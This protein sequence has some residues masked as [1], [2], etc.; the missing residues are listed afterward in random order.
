[1]KRF[2][3]LRLLFLLPGI[4]ALLVTLYA[5]GNPDWTEQV[6]SRMVYPVLSAAVGF[7]PSLVR[8]SVAEWWVAL[9]LLFCFWYVVHCIRRIV[10]GRGVLSRKAPE[11]SGN[12]GRG[13]ILYRSVVGALAIASMLYFAFTTLCG[14]NYYRHTFT[15]YTGYGVEQSSVEEL[16]QL[17]VSL[18]GGLNQTRERL[19]QDVDLVASDREDFDQCAQDSVSAIRALAEQYPVLERPLYSEPKPVA[20][21]GLMSDAGIAGIFFP[22]TMESNVND[23]IPLFTIPSTMTHELAHQCGFMREDEANFIAYLACKQADDPLARYSGQYLAFV[24]SVS[25]LRKVDS[26]AASG[27]LSG[28]SLTVQYD[29]AENDRFWDEHEGAITEISNAAND[30]YLKANSQADGVSSYGRMVDLLLAEQRASSAG[31][32]RGE[33]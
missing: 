31:S 21:S 20:L 11:A 29:M 19:G 18:A 15:S 7:L 16:E 27:V 26:E 25:A 32:P 22:F 23:D 8:F 33:G 30:T 6:Y 28:L 2:F 24:H 1:M 3:P 4:G 14:L 17:C 9:F 10:V 12:L 5:Q 13:V